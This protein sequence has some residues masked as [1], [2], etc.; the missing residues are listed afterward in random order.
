MEQREKR[1]VPVI[2]RFD[3]EGK[4]RPLVIEFDEAHKYPVDRILDVR[5]GSLSA[6]RRCWGPLYLPH[7]GQGNLSMAGK[8]VLVRGGKSIR[9]PPSD[10]KTPSD[11]GFLFASCRFVHH[12]ISS[13]H[14]HQLGSSQFSG[15]DDHIGPAQFGKFFR[16][17]FLACICQFLIFSCKPLAKVFL[18]VL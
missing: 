9:N 14:I 16:A 15:M 5:A 18:P 7:T 2:V 11:G 3:T 1:Y 13:Q 6:G 17:Q 12:K 4:L 10:G 8:R